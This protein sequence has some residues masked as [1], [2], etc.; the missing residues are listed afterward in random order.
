VQGTIPLVEGTDT[1]PRARTDNGLLLEVEFDTIRCGT[2]ERVKVNVLATD[3]SGNPVEADL[4]VSIV[5][6]CLFDDHRENI[7]NL[8]YPS[9]MEEPGVPA[10]YLP[11]L[12][13][14]VLR[15]IMLN[16]IT[17][18]PVGNENIVLSILGKAARC[19]IYKT[20]SMGEFYFNLD[21][22]GVK[23]MVIQPVNSAVSDYYVE[24]EPDFHNAYD[25]PF[26]GP[27][28]LDTMKLRALNQAIINMQIEY[29]YNPYR[30]HDRD[31]T[32]YTN[33]IDFY[34]DPE[35]G[36]QIAD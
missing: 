21:D 1:S 18:E 7:L 22:S 10:L 13:G 25:H 29:I 31:G 33:E 30:D 26:P 24:L 19:Q 32:P 3:T 16:S 11:E 27:L 28:Y 8:D 17:D 23:E 20:N 2:R 4:S 36:I 34:G 14:L 5:K 12:E 15:G 9:K 6:S 35:Y